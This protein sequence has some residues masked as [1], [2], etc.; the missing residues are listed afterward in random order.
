MKSKTAPSMARTNKELIQQAMKEGKMLDYV[1]VIDDTFIAPTLP[2]IN[3]TDLGSLPKALGARWKLLQQSLWS[4][5]VDLWSLYW[6]GRWKMKPPLPITPR[7]EI[8][9]IAKQMYEDIYTAFGEGDLELVKKKLAPGFYESLTKHILERQPDT[10]R[11]WR[12]ERYVREPKVVS[13]R[14]GPIP[15]EGEAA[16]KSKAEQAADTMGMVQAVVQIHSV[17]S[18]LTVRTT[19]EWDAVTRRTI[20]RVVPLNQRGVEISEGGAEEVRRASAK[21]TIEYFVI[22]RKVLH[23]KTQPWEAWGMT[24]ESTPEVLRAQAGIRAVKMK[25]LQRRRAAGEL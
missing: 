19:R 2:E 1:G 9:D 6:Q 3:Y 12:L 16:K 18:L 10:V 22:Q 17:Q 23:S 21:E 25:E 4:R 20:T 13:Y 24:T 14:F 11:K 15:A 7:K 8:K 5:M